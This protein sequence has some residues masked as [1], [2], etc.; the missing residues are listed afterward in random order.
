MAND[1]KQQKS[2]NPQGERNDR[3]G[4][5]NTPNAP[6]TQ[7]AP[8]KQNPTTK[9]AGDRRPQTDGVDAPRAEQ[10]TPAGKKDQRP[11]QKE[12][13]PEQKSGANQPNAG[14]TNQPNPKGPTS[15]KNPNFDDTDERQPREQDVDA[16]KGARQG[17]GDRSNRS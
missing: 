6:R 13:R 8:G 12:Q 4:T 10:G 9:P 17:S 14:G 1:P 7:D 11:D 5:S 3:Q 15:T 2:N 16:G